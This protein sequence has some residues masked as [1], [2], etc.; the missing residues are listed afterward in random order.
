MLI[1]LS[2]R[3]CGYLRPKR[4]RFDRVD[5]QSLEIWTTTTTRKLNNS[6]SIATQNYSI[7]LQALWMTFCVSFYAHTVP[8]RLQY[9]RLISRGYLQDG[10]VQEEGTTGDGECRT[11]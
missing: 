11:S 3:D 2:A 7:Q 10:L 4:S 9:F 5:L 1:S 6:D 8:L